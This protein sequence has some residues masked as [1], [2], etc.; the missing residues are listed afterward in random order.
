MNRLHSIERKEKQA[1]HKIAYPAIGEIYCINEGVT[2]ATLHEI[3][4]D[5]L[6]FQEGVAIS[7]GDIVLDVGANIGIFTLFAAKHGAQVYAY[8]PI[9]PTFEV[10]QHNI[11][12]H[13][14]DGLAHTR[15]IG[16]SDR[17]EEKLMFHYPACS[18]CD[19]WTAQDDLFELMSENWQDTLSLLETADP[20]QYKAISN[21][22][23][24]T[25]Q[26]RAVREIMET[27]SASPEQIKCQFDTLSG[28]I[29]R[30]NIQS[31]GLLKVDAEL[32]D[33]EILNGLK[34]E[35][36]P[37]IRQIAMEVHVESDVAPISNFLRERGFVRVIGKKLKMG[38][39]CLWAGR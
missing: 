32:A 26:Q 24:K 4:V 13:R 1:I 11:R 3:F 30:E 29:A 38:T 8:E 9:P 17:V 23:S 19:S 34:A 36:W 6:Y 7:S 28:V 39:N 5:K 33:W 25:L 12:L 27:F 31:I 2:R 15:N 35:D 10:L 22:G 14:L 18:V 21:L 16:V 37:R 20:D